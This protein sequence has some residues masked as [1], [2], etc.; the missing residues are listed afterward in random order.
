MKKETTMCA[1]IVSYEPDEAIIRLYDSICKQVDAVIIVDNASI[2]KTS[3]D[4]LE[5]LA[6]KV[7]IIYNDKNYGVAKALN[8]GALYAIENNYKWL[9]TLDQDSKFSQGTYDLL[10]ESYDTL[11]D[12]EKIMLI[13]P[14]YK[15]EIYSEETNIFSIPEIKNIIWEKQNFII[16]S[17]SL[18]KTEAFAKA[19]FFEE[20]LFID[21]VDFDFCLKLAQ[22][23]FFSLIASNVYF[24]HRLS[25]PAIKS[26]IKIFNYPPVRR[27][28][29]ARNSVFLFKKYFFYSPF[30]MTMTLVRSGIFF[31]ALKILLF[32]KNKFEKIKNIYKGFIDGILNKYQS[33]INNTM[34]NIIIFT[35]AGIGDFLWTTSALRLIKDA[36][37]E[38][39]V[40][41]VTFNSNLELT[42]K[43]L[44]IDEFILINNKYYSSKNIF[45][46]YVYKILFCIINYRKLRRYDNILFLDQVQWITFASKY[47]F[48]IKNIIG[49][50]LAWFGYNIKNPDAKYYTQAVSMPAYSDIVHMS[51]RY[52]ILIRALFNTYNLSMPVFPDTSYL[53]DKIKNIIGQTK[54]YKVVFCMKGSVEW[55]YWDLNY[56]K[57][58]IEKLD[59]II[60]VTFFIAG[61]NEQRKKADNLKAGVPNADIRNFCGKTTLSE[62]HEFFKSTDLLISVDTG[63]IHI[64]SLAKIPVISMHGTTLPEQSRPMSHKA[65]PLCS[66]RDCAPCNDKIALTGKICNNIQCM[67]D[68]TPEI[69]FEEAKKILLKEDTK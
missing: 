45:V 40:M 60:D 13:A 3:K 32:E 51:V 46:R 31:A 68:I 18:I 64:A 21:K 34:K 2:R 47:F 9:L 4:I 14:Q 66:Y 26:G 62:L 29:I 39:K 10:I 16:T 27:Y 28:Y 6:K 61:N 37:N 59:E 35:S 57:K 50:D 24:S 55:R 48:R 12:K 69:V 63:C 43:K 23:G 58:V 11:P 22:K 15:E 1:V 53:S 36:G 41:L 42:D 30:S 20:K 25:N 19:G 49:P 8:Q 5:S 52:Q 38:I 54:K 7:K 65:V 56:F 67:Y 44:A 17:G 33:N